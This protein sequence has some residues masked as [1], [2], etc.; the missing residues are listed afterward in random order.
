MLQS[1]KRTSDI[2]KAESHCLDGAS[3]MKKLSLA[4]VA[5]ALLLVAPHVRGGQHLAIRVSPVVAIAPAFLT[6][7][8]T[9]EPND[10]NRSLNV[11][12]D[13]G[14]Y[15]TS[16]EIPL[17]GR[18]SA[19]LS[20]IEIKDVPSGLYEVRAILMGSRGPIATT[21][22]LVKIEPAAGRQH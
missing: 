1:G 11:V 22:R 9:I 7:R 5:S 3:A 10:D 13:S 20:V 8:T 18:N 14:D 2:D 21:M 12:L 15:S 17:E 16:S 6:I 19:R 4:A